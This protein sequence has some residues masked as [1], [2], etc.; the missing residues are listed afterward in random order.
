MVAMEAGATVAVGSSKAEAGPNAGGFA[1]TA[2]VICVYVLLVISLP[3]GAIGDVLLGA[4]LAGLVFRTPH[5]VPVW[6]G[7]TL[8][9]ATALALAVNS[10]VVAES[11]ANYAYYGL[12]VGCLWAIWNGA[13]DRFRW[14]MPATA[15]HEYLSRRHV[16]Q[17]IPAPLL[18]VTFVLTG[19]AILVLDVAGAAGTLA[20]GLLVFTGLHR[21][22][23]TFLIS[24]GATLV[25][26]SD[27]L[28]LE[29]LRSPAI[30]ADLLACVAFLLALVQFGW[31][32]LRR[33]LIRRGARQALSAA[34]IPVG[35]VGAPHPGQS[36]DAMSANV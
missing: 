26:L 1:A 32:R 33:Q 30:S 21:P 4:A 23:F 25:V 36:T 11:L 5:T 14:N 15:L 34:E 19:A 28:F 29:D 31:L 2:G 22:R 20:A 35:A 7:L 16:Y 3:I 10:A 24:A 18:T 13:A 12:A 9:V 17:V 8:L 27:L 6:A